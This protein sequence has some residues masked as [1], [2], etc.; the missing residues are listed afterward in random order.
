MVST[1]ILDRDSDDGQI[2][3]DMT[4]SDVTRGEPALKVTLRRELSFTHLVS[5]TVGMMVGI[6]IFIT[7]V[8]IAAECGSFGL[9]MC[10]LVTSGVLVLLQALS[11]TELALM[12]PSAG[13]AYTYHREAVGPLFGF[14]YAWVRLTL[15]MPLFSAILSLVTAE[16]LLAIIVGCGVPQAANKC[17]AICIFGKIIIIRSISQF[18]RPV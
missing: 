10:I 9:S 11:Y 14:L 18:Y 15:I 12:Y 6:A 4:G 16:Y 2:R 13:E 17:I 8:T 5:Y 3:H 7:P 1:I